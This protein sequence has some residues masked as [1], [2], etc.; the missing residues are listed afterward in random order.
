MKTII[1]LILAFTALGCGGSGGSSYTSSNGTVTT[2]PTFAQKL[3]SALGS[4]K[5]SKTNSI[6][7]GYDDTGS[8]AIAQLMKY[9]INNNVKVNSD[10]VQPYELLNAEKFT[11]EET[12]TFGQFKISVGLLTNNTN[13]KGKMTYDL[14]VH[15]IAPV[16]SIDERPNFIITYCVDVSGSMNS[17]SGLA[18]L[19]STTKISMVKNG[20]KTSLK[21]LKNGDIINIVLFSS[22][23]S[24]LVEGYIVG[25]SSESAL[26]YLIES[27]KTSD[28]TNIEA[29]LDLAYEL[30]RKYFNKKKKNRVLMITD[31]TSNEG[32]TEA[33]VI[34]QN[35]NLENEEGILFSGLGIGYDYDAEFLAELTDKGSGNQFLAVSDADADYIFSSGLLP[36]LMLAAKNLKVEIIYPSFLS[37]IASA[38]E[39]TTESAEDLKGINFSYNA[40]QFYLERFQADLNTDVSKSEITINLTYL[41]PYNNKKKTATQTLLFS[42]IVKN[43]RSN[44]KDALCIL[45]LTDLIKGYKSWSDIQ[46]AFDNIFEGHSSLLYT[47]YK[48]LIYKYA[49][50]KDTDAF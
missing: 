35:V 11:S 50:K 30:A 26:N 6:F 24:I 41:D 25:E 37:H 20:L 42:Q 31:A 44:I 32:N 40:S 3:Q 43:E 8:T 14:G 10:L 22:D 33:S 47:E 27:I 46:W 2:T 45:F 49:N 7:V 48:A 21:Q 36:L 28:T 17:S 13:E 4:I 39:Q 29:G 12:T 38:A 15:L 18:S 23:A 5:N 16:L 9:Q 1:Y 19:S 34:A